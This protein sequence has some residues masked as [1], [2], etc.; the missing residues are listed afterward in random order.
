MLT[1]EAKQL[2]KKICIKIKTLASR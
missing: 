2:P 1:N